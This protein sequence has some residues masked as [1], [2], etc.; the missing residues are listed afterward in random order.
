LYLNKYK[1]KYSENTKF[2]FKNFFKLLGDRDLREKTY[3]LRNVIKQNIV[4]L[5]AREK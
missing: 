1:Q 5:K 3:L 2:I 4:L